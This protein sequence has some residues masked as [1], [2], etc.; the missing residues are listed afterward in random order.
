MQP[1]AA[2]ADGPG[3]SGGHPAFQLHLHRW[4]RRSGSGSNSPRGRRQGPASTALP[5][6]PAGPS[7]ASAAEGARPSHPLAPSPA[8]HRQRPG[9]RA[10]AGRHVRARLGPARKPRPAAPTPLRPPRLL[11]LR[12]PRHLGRLARHVAPR[13]VTPG[14]RFPDGSAA[15]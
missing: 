5:A 3:P 10:R 2:R 15:S 13:R 12:K 9:P 14:P 11:R 8:P 6:R 7:P 1:V 4:P